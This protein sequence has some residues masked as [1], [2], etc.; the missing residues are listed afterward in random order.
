MILDY[1]TCTSLNITFTESQEPHI[2]LLAL[3]FHPMSTS[4]VITY[5]TH[6]TLSLA[7]WIERRILINKQLVMLP[8]CLG[9]VGIETIWIVTCLNLS[10]INVTFYSLQ[11]LY[12]MATNNA[13][14]KAAVEGFLNAWFPGGNVPKTPKG[15]AFR[16]EWGSLR[17][18]GEWLFHSTTLLIFCD[19]TNGS[20]ST[21]LNQKSISWYQDMKNV[22]ILGY[23]K[24]RTV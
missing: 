20:Q 9:I 10:D 18:A 2:Q 22:I 16:N 13:Q 1:Q 17:Y 5:L 11:L 19:C 7:H 15:L 21:Y 8:I 4:E 6:N 24:T 14:Y 23:I 12:Y 3:T